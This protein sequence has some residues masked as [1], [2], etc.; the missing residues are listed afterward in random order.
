MRTGGFDAATRNTNQLFLRKDTNEVK[1]NRV[2]NMS[3][4]CFSC[5]VPSFQHFFASGGSLPAAQWIPNDL[6]Q[7]ASGLSFVAWIKVGATVYATNWAQ[8]S[9]VDDYSGV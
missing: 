2:S 7:E 1:K 5:S 6:L 3:H 9:I 8:L 4:S